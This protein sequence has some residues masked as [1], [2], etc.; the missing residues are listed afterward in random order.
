[1]KKFESFSDAVRYAYDNQEH[2]QA[3]FTRNYGIDK[4]QVSNLLKGEGPA[5]PQKKTINLWSKAL[6]V[7]IKISDDGKWEVR[8]SHI[9]DYGTE[10]RSR[11]ISDMRSEYEKRKGARPPSRTERDLLIEHLQERAEA[12]ARDLR[13]LR[14]LE[15][16][17]KGRNED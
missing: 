15:D 13:R 10:T 1:M 5:K 4:A 14:D 9:K 3:Y 8:E 7:D 12:L 6:G 11:M 16:N 2:N 17:R